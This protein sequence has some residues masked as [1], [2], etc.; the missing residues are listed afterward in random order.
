MVRNF[1]STHIIIVAAG[2]GSRFGSAVPKQFC[3]LQG[4]PVVM[5]TIDALRRACPRAL[6]S[7][8]IS[9]SEQARW[10]ELCDRFGFESP[11]IVF[12]GASR[13]E[14]VRNALATS[15]AGTE[16]IMVHDGARPLVSDSM[17][18]KLFFTLEM[19]QAD[20][21]LPALDVSDS[22]RKFEVINDKMYSVAVN[23]ALYRT[24]QT[25]QLFPAKVLQDSYHRADST[26]TYT[27]DASVVEAA[28]YTNISLS[29]GSHTNIKITN[30]GDIELAEF[31]LSHNK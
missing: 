20:G 15:P 12:G 22:L 16:Y 5:H 13:F 30:P 18:E 2:T 27:D 17:I 1:E 14:S 26:K 6:I 29:P 24:V 10:S 9:D 31:Y 28:G 7:L 3:L 8:V 11:E 19:C 4:R 21:A 23:R 25:P